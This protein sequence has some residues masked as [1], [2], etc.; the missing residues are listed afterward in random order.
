MTGTIEELESIIEKYTPLLAKV[1]FIDWAKKP[2]PN[3]WSKK[4][5]LGHLVDSAQNNIRRFIVG[6]Y[7]NQPYIIYNQDKWA[8][9]TNYQDYY[10]TGDLFLLWLLLNKHICAILKN[11]T[12]ENS[13][14][15][16]KTQSLNSIEWL[17][18]DYNKHLLHHLHHILDL[19]AV[20]Y[21]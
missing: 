8:E 14:R 10:D 18:A 20:A 21:P 3:K 15:L 7:E 16:V 11:T 13:L 9:I 4:E 17:A 1:D 6:Q 12:S 19:E 5:E 2:L